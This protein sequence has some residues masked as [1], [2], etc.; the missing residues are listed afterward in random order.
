MIVVSMF[1]PR[2]SALLRTDAH[3]GHAF[4]QSL[5]LRLDEAGGEEALDLGHRQR[6]PA[7]PGVHRQTAQRLQP[8]IGEPRCGAEAEQAAHCARHTAGAGEATQR[9]ALGERDDAPFQ[10]R[11]TGRGRAAAVCARLVTGEANMLSR[12][13]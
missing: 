5:D 2:C 1:M 9:V 10:R 4:D 3:A 7:A 6:E 13:R 12:S 11:E 8:G